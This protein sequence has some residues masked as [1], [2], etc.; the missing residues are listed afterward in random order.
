[1]SF[2]GYSWPSNSLALVGFHSFRQSIST[3]KTKS[4]QITK[5]AK[6]KKKKKW[7]EELGNQTNVH[8]FF[9]VNCKAFN[10]MK[11]FVLSWGSLCIFQFLVV[12]II[13]KRI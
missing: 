7:R 3:R 4:N 9:L 12:E 13:S 11:I 5:K 10:E 2:I 6:K 8:F 1:M